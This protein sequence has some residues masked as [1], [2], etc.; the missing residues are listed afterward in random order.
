M[1]HL[2]IWVISSRFFRMIKALQ[3]TT[4]VLWQLQLLL[5]F[6]GLDVTSIRFNQKCIHSPWH[7]NGFTYVIAAT[8]DEPTSNNEV[9]GRTTPN[10][11]KSTKG[12][13][14]QMVQEFNDRLRTPVPKKGGRPPKP[15]QNC[16]YEGENVVYL[17]EYCTIYGVQIVLDFLSRSCF[18]NHDVHFSAA[19]NVSYFRPRVGPFTV[20]KRAC[21][22]EISTKMQARSQHG[23]YSG[24]NAR[25]RDETEETATLQRKSW[26]SNERACATGTT[27][28]RWRREQACVEEDTEVTDAGLPDDRSKNF[29]GLIYTSCYRVYIM[30]VLF[31]S[32]IAFP[33]L[34]PMHGTCGYIV[35]GF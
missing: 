2:Q 21:Q 34:I 28:K 22:G 16:P 33:E 14:L 7:L 12:D 5:P 13:W 27:V 15:I 17:V 25:K 35:Y 9:S 31:T 29:I 6:S 10:S 23:R 32:E 20:A 3:K 19:W 24:Q 18:P 30:Y 26:C 8:I 4:V 11:E 1:N